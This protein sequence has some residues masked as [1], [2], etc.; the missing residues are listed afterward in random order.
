MRLQATKF[1]SIDCTFSR[2]LQNSNQERS[3]RLD[4]DPSDWINCS[5][6]GRNSRLQFLKN[7]VD[8]MVIQA[9]GLINPNQ[10]ESPGGILMKIELTDDEPDDWIR[11]KSVLKK[12]QL[13]FKALTTQDPLDPICLGSK[14]EL[15]RRN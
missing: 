13:C 8:W 11:E 9:T 1:P 4:D 2:E 3:S 10:A 6:L 12:A 7:P 15:E 5:E 14:V